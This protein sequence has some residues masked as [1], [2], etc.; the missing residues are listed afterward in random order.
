MNT[1]HSLL[2]ILNS[3]SSP[4]HFDFHLQKI[5]LYY[6]LRILIHFRL[7]PSLVNHLR[8]SKKYR[9]YNCSLGYLMYLID[10]IYLFKSRN[11]NI[12]FYSFWPITKTK[13]FLSIILFNSSIHKYH[14]KHLSNI[15]PNVS[16]IWGIIFHSVFKILISYNF[17]S[18]HNLLF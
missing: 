4:S 12:S 7:Y 9:T 8:I 11:I 18:V 13:L 1:F 10:K 3:F 6:H 17:I 16:N 2:I 14:K 5:I 15:I